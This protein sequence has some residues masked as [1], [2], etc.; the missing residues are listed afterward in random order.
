MLGNLY[1]S[2]RFDSIYATADKENIIF[3]SACSYCFRL[4]TFSYTDL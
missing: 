2:I 1:F 3:N 4:T